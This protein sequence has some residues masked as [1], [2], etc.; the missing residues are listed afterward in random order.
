MILHV[1]VRVVCWPLARTLA[2]SLR[3]HVCRNGEC[4]CVRVRVLQ[5]QQRLRASRWTQAPVAMATIPSD[6]PQLP[7]ESPPPTPPPALTCYPPP[8]ITPPARAVAF[9]PVAHPSLYLPLLCLSFILSRSCSCSLS[10]SPFLFL[11]FTVCLF[12]SIYLSFSLDSLLLCFTH[13][14]S[15]RSAP[16][17]LPPRDPRSSPNPPPFS[18]AAAPEEGVLTTRRHGHPPFLPCLCARSLI[19]SVER[20]YIPHPSSCRFGFLGVA[21]G[22]V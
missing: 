13:L 18:S 3:M 14:L 1:Y 17:R 12:L 20:R 9:N 4:S 21:R 16:F 10:L 6:W 8:S 2:H 22:G 7:L 19:T 15:F 11:P 5:Q